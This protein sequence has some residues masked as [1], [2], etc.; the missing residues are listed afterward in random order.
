M[1]SDYVRT[2]DVLYSRDHL[3]H[4]DPRV[5][6]EDLDGVYY[7][8]RRVLSADKSELPEFVEGLSDDLRGRSE[9]K[10]HSN[11]LIK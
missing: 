8:L 5:V 4:H 11:L 9:L 2:L 10:V 1:C 7:L 6:D 3:T